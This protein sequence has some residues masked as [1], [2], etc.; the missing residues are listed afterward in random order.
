MKKGFAFA[1][2]VVVMIAV[3]IVTLVPSARAQVE[4]Q[5]LRWFRFEGPMGASVSVVGSAGFTPLRPT[6]L[7]AGFQSMAVGFNNESA[8]LSYWNSATNQI[9]VIDEWLTYSDDRPLPA[10]AE[11]TVNGQQA[12]LITGLEGSVTLTLLSPTPEPLH[13]ESPARVEG[14]VSVKVPYPTPT[15]VSDSS[16]QA[17]LVPVSPNHLQAETVSYTDGRRLVWYVGNIRIEMLSNLPAEEMLKIAE[18]M[19]PAEEG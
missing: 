14:S 2:I 6:Y 10:G 13:S 19:V 3:G 9:L 4:R 1:A 15:I 8:S 12:A 11:V 7:P 18:S 5:L 16:D 17:T